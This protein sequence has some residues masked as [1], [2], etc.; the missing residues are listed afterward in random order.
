VHRYVA[1]DIRYVS[2][3]LGLGGYQPRT[4]DEVMRTGFGDCKDKAT[5]FVA[6]LNRMGLEAHPVL[7]NSQ[8]GVEES[9]PSLTQFD[10]AI[11]A[12]RLPGETA[13]RYTDLTAEL[14]P[15]GELP[16]GPQGEFGIIV[17]P[18]GA[19][20]EI[21]FPLTTIAENRRETRL[22][23]TLD[24][25][26]YVSGS[27]EEHATGHLQYELRSMFA[28]PY[29]AEQTE[30]FRDGF[31]AAWFKGA[32]GSELEIF[33]GKDLAADPRV[34]VKFS[35]GQGVT[36]AG[37]TLA[38]PLP[39]DNMANL[40]GLIRQ[41]ETAGP[42]LQPIAAQSVFGYAE[43]L[44]ELRLTLPEGWTVQLPESVEV[45]SPF[46]RYRKVYAQEGRE[47]TVQRFIGGATGTLPPE[48]ID[49]LIA[50]LKALTVDNARVLVIDR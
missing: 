48:R 40:G 21:T 17:K 1:Q 3:A 4:P 11:A 16:F 2:I 36:M 33:A 24:E 46:G 19:V 26:G 31:A 47:L 12:Y 37:R 42:R 9:L 41:L 29:D 23:G 14:V 45:D 15:L 18:D 28:N 43:T 13:W 44:Q 35:G 22:V 5:I 25:E 30:Q 32:R 8:G 7:L 50:F 34:A 10:H 39:I 20:E 49:D 38:L 6:M 27:F